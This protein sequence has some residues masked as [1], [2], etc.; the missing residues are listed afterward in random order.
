MYPRYCQSRIEVA[1]LDSPVVIITGPR[2]SGKTTLA[3]SLS[4]QR[5]EYRTLDDLNQLTL[6]RHDPIGFI[7]NLQSDHIILDEIQR[8]PELFL[9][10][11][12]SVDEHRVPGKYLLT[13]SANVL[14]LPKMAD[15]LA[16][17][18]ETIP[19]LP[20]SACEIQRRESTFF[21]NVLSGKMPT[22]EEIRVRTSLIDKIIVG[23]FPEVLT[24]ST[25]ERRVA[26]HLQYMNSLIERDVKELSE[27][28]Y[29]SEMPTLV[30][31]LCSQVGKLTNYRELAGKIGL[32]GTTMMKYVSLLEQ[33]Y[34]FKPLAAWHQNENK[35]I[36]KT[37]KMHIVDT[38]LLCALMRVTH[39][40]LH[41]NPELLGT[42]VESYVV[43]ELQRLATWYPEPLYFYHYRDKDRVEV[44][45][46]IETLTGDIIGIEIKT[47]A[48]L[49]QKDFTGLKKLQKL[50]GKRFI[51][52]I[53]LYDGDH[54]TTFEDNL[55]AVPF[56]VL[57]R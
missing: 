22:T 1:L 15:S 51:M 31:L 26:W 11:K 42:L 7:R 14:V 45:I 34:L 36:I 24:R 12:Q 17:R 8:A 21:L 41:N 2:Q 48:T 9:A 54:S 44:D 4:D 53:V 19:L 40:K 23:G 37:P 52:G 10:I 47:S 13:G 35:R 32:S 39:E 49:E 3:K 27:I 56:S 43:C 38:G 18:M 55:H 50:T 6:A 57:W 5:R 20:L 29:L 33:L 46:V 25:Q 16:G 30:R 28:A